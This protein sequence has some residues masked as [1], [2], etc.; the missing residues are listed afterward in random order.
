[1]CLLMDRYSLPIKPRNVMYMTFSVTRMT[2]FERSMYNHIHQ[3][4]TDALYLQEDIIVES[5]AVFVNP[6]EE[7]VEQ[8]CICC[9]CY[10]YVTKTN[11]RSSNQNLVVNLQSVCIETILPLLNIAIKSGIADTIRF[12]H[13]SIA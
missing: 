7:A 8:V 13:Y 3:R 9:V 12:V 2:V 4:L 10:V 6:Y 5:C 1:M 11:I